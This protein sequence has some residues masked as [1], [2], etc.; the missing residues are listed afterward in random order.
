MKVL[1]IGADRGLGEVLSDMAAKI[2]HQVISGYYDLNGYKRKNADDGIK[3]L[4]MDVTDKKQLE[5]AADVIREEVGELDA[6]VDVAGVLLNSDRTDSIITESLED[7]SRHIEVN[8]IGLLSAYRT[9]SPIMKKGT[10]FYAV[11]S[12]AGSFTL[13]GTLF[14][15]YSVSKTAANKI[16]QVLRLTLEE[17]HDDRVD[18]V[19]VH[20][21]RMNTEMGRTT[22]QI[23]PEVSA[24]GFL[25]LLDKT[26]PVNSKENWFIDYQG[27]PMSV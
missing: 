5:K 16:V 19:A 3:R 15:A 24:E 17:N 8:A 21:G 10:T 1:I 18:V 6:V 22:A 11:T 20:P 2:G 9:F 23:E 14:P 7:I 13:A 4:Q 25:K 27:K 12:E 26:T